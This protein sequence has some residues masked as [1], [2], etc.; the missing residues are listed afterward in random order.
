MHFLCIVP[1]YV[2]KLHELR[3][4]IYFDC[5]RKHIWRTKMGRCPCRDMWPIMGWKKTADKICFVTHC[6]KKKCLTSLPGADRDTFVTNWL[7]N[8]LTSLPRAD[9][10]TFCNYLT[11]KLPYLSPW[12]RSRYFW[13]TSLSVA[14]LL[15][16]MMLK[17][18]RL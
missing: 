3:E 9:R 1:Y 11:K 18:K 15:F 8:R 14:A 16:C 6:I 5:F 7:K 12:G 13:S 2:A 4:H 17:K 10:D